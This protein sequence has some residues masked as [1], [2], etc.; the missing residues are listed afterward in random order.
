MRVQ[1]DAELDLEWLDT[2]LGVH[3]AGETL[4][5]FQGQRSG[6]L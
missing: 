5:P 1:D 6:K 2:F 4:L 3:A